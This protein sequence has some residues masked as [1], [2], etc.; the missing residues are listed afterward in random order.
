VN[1]RVEVDFDRAV[2]RV[3][4]TLANRSDLQALP[5]DERHRCGAALS[6]FEVEGLRRCESLL[7]REIAVDSDGRATDDALSPFIARLRQVAT[8]IAHQTGVV[9]EVGRRPLDIMQIYFDHKGMGHL[10]RGGR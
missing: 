9:I 6:S 8:E 10:L 2:M 4:I 5:D 7:N 1:P 3:D